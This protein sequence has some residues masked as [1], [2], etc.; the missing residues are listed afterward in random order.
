MLT[1]TP[2]KKR[3]RSLGC[4]N[5][6]Q[7]KVESSTL[8]HQWEVCRIYIS[9]SMVPRTCCKKT[10]VL[11]ERRSVVQPS[12]LVVM[13]KFW[14]PPY[15]YIF[16]LGRTFTSSLFPLCGLGSLEEACPLTVSKHGLRSMWA[17]LTLTFF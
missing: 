16:Y 11:M 4:I 12:I 1:P 6:F 15:M 14:I 17:H 8:P 7:I 2:A 3:E 13:W 9:G 10:S 5:V